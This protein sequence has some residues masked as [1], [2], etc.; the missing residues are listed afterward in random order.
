MQQQPAR[1]VQTLAQ[2]KISVLRTLDTKRSTLKT[3]AAAQTLCPVRHLAS[4]VATVQYRSLA[5]A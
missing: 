2:R 4:L 5:M 1:I 3:S